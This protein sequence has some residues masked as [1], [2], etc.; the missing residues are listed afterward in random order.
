SGQARLRR[1]L[2]RRRPRRTAGVEQPPDQLGGRGLSRH[3]CRPRGSAHGL[4]RDGSRR[5][6][7]LDQRDATI[8]ALAARAVHL[9]GIGDA[10]LGP[11][12]RVT[13]SWAVEIDQ[14]ATG[15]ESM[16]LPSPTPSK[17]QRTWITKVAAP[18][19]GASRRR[20][21]KDP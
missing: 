10:L 19:R 9:V 6:R 4:L 11:L 14:I 2:A 18:T 16:A 21:V 8:L 3:G 5:P 13:A 12:H 20:Q 15:L 1:S 7:G 17:P